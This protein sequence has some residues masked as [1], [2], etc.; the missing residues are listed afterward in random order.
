LLRKSRYSNFTLSSL[1]EKY[2][3]CAGDLLEEMKNVDTK[4]VEEG[5]TRLHSYSGKNSKTGEV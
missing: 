3:Y 4:I 1:K 2:S 5:K